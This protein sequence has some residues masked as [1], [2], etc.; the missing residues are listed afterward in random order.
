[1]LEA[2]YRDR[3]ET[4]KNEL[5]R[6]I[7]SKI[8]KDAN[9][10][11]NYFLKNLTKNLENITLPTFCWQLYLDKSNFLIK[12]K[13]SYERFKNFINLRKDNL[14]H[15]YLEIDKIIEGYLQEEKNFFLDIFNKLDENW[16]KI[17]RFFKLRS[18][19]LFFIYP[20]ASDRHTKGKRTIFLKFENKKY[21]K[22]K[23]HIFSYQPIFSYIL[24]KFN[25]DLYKNLKNPKSIKID[26]LWICEFIPLKNKNINKNEAKLFYENLGNLWGLVFALNGCDF[27]MENIIAQGW[28][29]IILDTETF[30]TN[31]SAYKNK[32]LLNSLLPTGFIESPK[33]K[34]L[35]SAIYGGNKKLISLTQPLVLYKF[36]DRMRLKYRTFSKMQPHNRIFKNEKTLWNPKNFKKQIIKGFKESYLWI[37]K[38]RHFILKMI[39]E[40]KDPIFSRVILRKTS[41]YSILIQHILQPINFPLKKF[42]LRLKKALKENSKR[43]HYNYHKNYFRKIIQYEI[44]NLNKLSIPIFW[45]NIK[46]KNLYGEGI[47]YKNV[48]PKTAFDMLTE[49]FEKISITKLNN[50]IQKIENYLT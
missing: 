5:K 49:K 45:Q 4:L 35:T 29:P 19:L 18:K 46:E 31:Y 50:Y 6:S 34:N 23:P 39:D 37:L 40:Q 28:K 26:D 41:F 12:G 36:T 47:K 38:N 16:S 30:F 15:L 44:D 10:F 21:L 48:F 7:K 13:N 32:S 3:L 9:F 22:I 2:F 42:N 11:I 17:E 33:S 25:K 14:F 27:H 1:M 43:F 20:Q 24:E 8:I